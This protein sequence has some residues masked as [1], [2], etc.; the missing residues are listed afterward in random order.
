MGRIDLRER[1]NQELLLLDGA[2][3]TQLIA[4]GVEVGKCNDYLNIESPEIISDIHRAYLKAGS[5]AIIT[6]TFGGNRYALLRHGFADKAVEINTEGAAVAREAAGDD[7]YVLG[8][9]GPAGDFLEPLGPLKCNELKE[10]FFVQAKALLD[11]GVDGFIIET[12]TAVDEIVVAIEVVKSACSLPVF[13]SLAFDTA[14]E[15]FGTMMGIGVEQAVSEIASFGVEALGFNCGAVSLENYIKLAE[16]YVAAVSS[17]GTGVKVLAEPNA[18]LP[19]LVDGRAVYNVSPEDFA[20]AAEKIH[21]A[22]ISIIGG[23]CGTAPAHIAAVV[24]ILRD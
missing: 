2:M 19:E 12:M 5:D 21:S 14:G 22:G 13:V 3:G 9:I 7:K 24:N 18:G 23:C 15:D 8:D 1:I 6:N 16:R 17:A 10:A 4:R 20:T 11:G